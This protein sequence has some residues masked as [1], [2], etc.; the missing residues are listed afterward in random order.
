MSMSSI[1]D[2]IGTGANAET[3]FGM[4]GI[5]GVMTGEKIKQ[6]LA[7]LHVDR[8]SVTNMI[9]P[10]LAMTGACLAVVTIASAVK[11]GSPWA[12]INSIAAGLGL[13]AVR[14]S[15]HFDPV[16]SVAGVGLA[17]GG[18]VV[19][20]GI[21][22]VVS[23]V[24]SRRMGRGSRIASGVATSLAAVAMDKLFMRDAIFPA[25]ANALGVRGTVLKYGA[26]GAAAALASR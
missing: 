4:R 6:A 15:R 12:G 20:A 14:P 1:Q 2:G 24:A 21:H 19:L 11:R 25:F 9:V 18:S 3:G 13:T 10:A 16:V 5:R 23:R 26:I 22:A 7:S 17:I 8:S